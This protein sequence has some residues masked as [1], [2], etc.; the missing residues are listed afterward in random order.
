MGAKP[1]PRRLLNSHQPLAVVSVALRLVQRQQF[2]RQGRAFTIGDGGE[3]APALL[4]EDWGDT[5]P[6]CS[7][8]ANSGAGVVGGR[9]RTH[10]EIVR[11]EV[12]RAERGDAVGRPVD[13]KLRFL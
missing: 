11:R 3:P 7:P 9:D 1:S 6:A 10:V 13:P 4:L 5:P 8:L 2:N 12:R